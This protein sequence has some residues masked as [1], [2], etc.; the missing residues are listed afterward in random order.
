MTTEQAIATL[1]RVN[2]TLSYSAS[3]ATWSRP[4]GS[5]YYDYSA[6]VHPDIRGNDCE[7]FSAK[8]MEAVVAQVVHYLT[9]PKPETASE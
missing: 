7:T 9:S 2:S 1:R 4:D 5:I 8:S 3:K 6:S